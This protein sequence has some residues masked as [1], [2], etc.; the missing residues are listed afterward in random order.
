MYRCIEN[1]GGE[2]S[3][4]E[5]GIGLVCRFDDDEVLGPFSRVI[6]VGVAAKGC[7]RCDS[8]RFSRLYAV[9][10]MSVWI[11]LKRT[12]DSLSP[13]SKGMGIIAMG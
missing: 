2:K 9:L 12:R 6:V 5:Q 4:H 8:L 3:K 7:V 10:E 13:F 1:V 11:G